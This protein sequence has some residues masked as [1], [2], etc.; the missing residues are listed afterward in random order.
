MSADD[1]LYAPTTR[2][3]QNSIGTGGKM[4]IGDSEMSA[5]GTLVFLIASGDY[6]L[7]PL[8]KKHLPTAECEN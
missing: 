5:M 7:C 4:Y 3:I 6:Y 1:P 8:E 2:Q